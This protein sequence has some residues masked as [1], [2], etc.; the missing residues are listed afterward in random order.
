MPAK[1]LDLRKGARRLGREE[2]VPA[3]RRLDP[4]DVDVEHD[5]WQQLSV[6]DQGLW[7]L[8]VPR[9]FGADGLGAFGQIVRRKE[10]VQHRN[11]LYD[12][13]C[14]LLGRF[15]P[16]FGNECASEQLERSITP[17]LRD[18]HLES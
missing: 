15:H 2:I 4:E 7:A 3:E 8:W 1:L 18:G 16:S 5:D 10:M 17:A 14:G 13:G 11:G 9:R 12:P 6:K